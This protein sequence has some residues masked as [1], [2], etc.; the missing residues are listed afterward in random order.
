M[1]FNRVRTAPAIVA[2]I[3]LAGSFGCAGAQSA[4]SSY[5]YGEMFADGESGDDYDR[6]SI[7][8]VEDMSGFASGTRG[9][10]IA[11]ESRAMPGRGGSDSEVQEEFE[12]SYDMDDAEPPPEP[13]R[14]MSRRERRQSAPEPVQAAPPAPPMVQ[15]VPTG[16]STS[17]STE[18]SGA[19]HAASLMDQ[20]LLAEANTTP[21]PSKTGPSNQA[22]R[23]K[24]RQ[25]A[26]DA[27]GQGP[28]LIYEAQL[29]LA[30]HEVRE[31]IDE[32]IA[33][34]DEVGGFISTQ[35][36]N[37]IVVRIPAAHFRDSLERIEGVGD[38][39]SRRVSAQD[40]SDQVRDVRIRLRNAIQMR[41]RMAELLERAQ[42]VPDS[43]TIERELERLTQQI[44]LLR[45]QL[46]SLQDRI[47]YS[48]ITVRFQAVRTDHDVP[49]ERFR[50]PFPW[51]NELGLANLLELR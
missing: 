9:D 39:L 47:A 10:M 5:R 12:A 23:Q 8:D 13:S 34:T 29:S 41:D 7:P 43:L 11:V 17:T 46:Q 31:K 30:V 6:D 51:L 49:R 35:D 44:E 1:N 26:T 42:T 38:V 16:G 2:L 32:I 50:L 27:Q 20:Q 45:G 24:N 28:L 4:P 19:E 22:Q 14:R 18:S 25:T 21:T 33:I 3:L 15:T 40:V 36:D 37:S 48:T